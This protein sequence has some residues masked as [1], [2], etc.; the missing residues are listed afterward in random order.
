VASRELMWSKGITGDAPSVV[1][2]SFLE[3]WQKKNTAT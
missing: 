2:F 3:L 1:L